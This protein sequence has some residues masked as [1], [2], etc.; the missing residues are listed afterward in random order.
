M[1]A[2]T[3]VTVYHART[4]ALATVLIG[5]LCVPLVGQLSKD[6][7]LIRT[8]QSLITE[9]TS[10]KTTP[11]L[12]TE[13]PARR[14]VSPW[15]LL[16]A[17]DF[18]TPL[19]GATAPWIRE[20]YSN[21][22]DT[23]MDDHG[24][25]HVNDYGP[26]WNSAFNS[27]ATY[28]KEFTVGEDGWLTVSLSARDW[29]KDGLI[30]AP[31]SISTHFEGG[32][33]VAVLDVPDHTGGAIFR[34]TNKLP[35]QYRVEYKLKTIDF[36]GKRNG[37]LDYDSRHNGY[38]NVGCKTQHPWGEGSSSQ[39]WTGDASV[40][41]CEWQDVRK[42]P[43]GYNGFHFLS[44]VDV[45][46]PA[47]RN[48]HFWHYHRK[49]LIDA[50]SQHPDRVSSGTGGRI[51][52]SSNNQYYDYLDSSFNTVNMW[53]SGLPY[54]TPRSGHMA[55]NSQWFMTSCSAGIAEQQ[56]SSA[57]ELQPELMPNEF[58]IFA[59]E[60]STTGY[61]LEASGNFTRVGQKTLRF[62]RPFIV[63]NVP[64]WHY[65]NSANEYDGRFNADLVQNAAHGSTTWP[66]QWPAG[67]SY[68]DYLVIGDPYTN[69]YEGRASLTDI[70][71]YVPTVAQEPSLKVTAPIPQA[72]INE[73]T[74]NNPIPV[75]TSTTAAGLFVSGTFDHHY[76]I[77]V[78]GADGMATLLESGT[79]PPT[80]ATTSYHLRST[81]VSGRRYRWR[82]RA[83]LNG[84]YGPWSVWATFRYGGETVF[85]AAD[86][87]YF[88]VEVIAAGLEAPSGLSFAPDGRL[89]VTER[90]GRIRIIENAVLLAKPALILSDVLPQS[91]AGALDITLHPQFNENRY[92]YLVYTASS[93]ERDPVIRLVRYRELENTL[94]ERIVLF[95]A[96]VGAVIHDGA[97]VRFG[98]D[99][100]LYMTLG[101]SNN[102][103]FAQDLAAFNG[104]IFRLN[105][106]GTVPSDNPFASPIFSY[107]HR[108]PQ[109]LAWHPISGDLWATE[110][111]NIGNDELNVISSG[112]NY[113]WPVIE[114]PLTRPGMETP[115]QLYSPSIAPSGATFYTG[116]LFPTFTN[117]LF[118]ATLVGEHLHRIRLDPAD[119]RRVQY[120]ERLLSGRFGRLRDVVMGLDGALYIATNNT[121]GRGT[122]AAG[123]DRIL[124]L[125]PA[126]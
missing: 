21:P 70:R 55:G 115:I 110:H 43:L 40:P 124:R 78:V 12:P 111:G 122:P 109:G 54:W 15:T 72:P 82:V 106:D 104:K 75:L 101:D 11:I 50:F 118:F 81:L 24:L 65:N 93:P 119:P 9:E 84:F 13:T 76:E 39:G 44:I 73:E 49:V 33:Y 56:L 67:S 18:S 7:T 74:V 62:H 120:D 46:N 23:I 51:C 36:G 125:V 26:V 116:S 83:G 6:K 61:T 30:E 108:N 35:S 99:G 27:F 80:T 107:G 105:A 57:A 60:R 25:W 16:Y 58:Y 77:S 31:P 42:G 114:G 90:P 100:K 3:R 14:L 41:Y 98:P 87:T 91:E 53:M 19:S 48:N 95:E 88:K 38:G 17:E 2:E 47:P 8:G 1:K 69:V 85:T 68:P 123:D 52:N 96:A 5:S 32:E 37:T 63:N 29:N 4:I 86:G 94:A 97:R 112:N 92:V 59:I 28:R 113:G 10:E 102:T 66:D 22:F 89:F 45:A 117:N 20:D 71:L 103:S 64:I 121:D 79:V 34:S 126:L